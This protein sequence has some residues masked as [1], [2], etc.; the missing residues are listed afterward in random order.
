MIWAALGGI[1]TQGCLLGRKGD[2]CITN[3][4]FKLEEVK[5]GYLSTSQ[6]ERRGLRCKGRHSEEI[7]NP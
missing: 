7:Y 4:G 5:M 3:Q 1:R 6:S 2:V